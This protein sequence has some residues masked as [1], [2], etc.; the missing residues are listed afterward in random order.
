MNARPIEAFDFGRMAFG[1]LPASFILEAIVRF[2][3]LYLT[4][5]TAFRLMGRRMSSQLTRNELMALV[6]LA[7]AIGPA[8]QDP[9]QGL[10]PPLLVAALVTV[11]QRSLANLSFRSHRFEDLAEG[12]VARLVED[13]HLVKRALRESQ[14][15]RERLFAELRREGVT[16]LGAV[17]RVYFEPDGSF[18]VVRAQDA[19]P[20]LSLVPAWDS[21]LVEREP[22]DPE[23]Q[24][25]AEC[26]AVVPNAQASGACC[27][28]GGRRYLPAVRP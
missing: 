1:G 13:G 23:R 15:S 26:G 3:V 24:A 20:G 7:A 18:S 6:S 12:R 19:A 11:I 9:E 28:C 4:L 17:E 10:L 14:V 25:C 5:V 2:I 22:K 27:L 21:E 16:T 8:L